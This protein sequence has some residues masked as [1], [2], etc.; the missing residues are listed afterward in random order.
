MR[1][2]AA[3]EGDLKQYMKEEYQT[4]ERRDALGIH[5]SLKWFEN[6]YAYGGTSSGLSNVW[7][8]PGVVVYP[9]R[10]NS[11][12]AAVWFIPRPAKSWRVLMKVIKSRTAG[13]WRSQLQMRQSVV[14]VVSGLSPISLSIAMASF[15]LYIAENGL[16]YWVVE[17]VQASTAVKN[18]RITRFRKASKRNR[19]QTNSLA[20]VMFWL[21]PRKSN[22]QN[23]FV[24]MKKPSA[25]MTNCRDWFWKTGQ[26]WIG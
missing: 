16:S 12:R 13:G 7:P 23:S 17:N 18:R 4:A 11:I 19:G 26:I 21:V 1:L 25:G 15:V 6:G 9:H 10:Q 2:K 8:I 3:I 20:R 5:W 22:C 24:S 14:W